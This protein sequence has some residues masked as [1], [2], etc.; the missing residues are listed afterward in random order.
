[1]D[2]TKKAEYAISILLELAQSKD[3]EFIPSREVGERQGVPANLIP[4][5]VAILSKQGWIE[6]IRGPRGGIRLAVDPGT[7]S[8]VSVIE[9]VEGPITVSRCLVQQGKSCPNQTGCPLRNVWARA[10]Q[11]VVEVL[12]DTS[13]QDLV[14]AQQELN[15]K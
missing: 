6:A 10:Q 13:I 3:K 11:K 8:L 7:I 14:V 9:A 12:G 1:M 4:Q 5:L 2:I 15:K